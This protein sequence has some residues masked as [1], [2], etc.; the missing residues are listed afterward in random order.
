MNKKY[1]TR[2][3][4]NIVLDT[5]TINR[6]FRIK[7]AGIINGKKVN[8]LVGVSGLLEILGGNVKRM[9][10]FLLRAFNNMADKTVCKIYGVAK[11]TFYAK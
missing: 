3:F 10:D 7:V 9:I 4:G 6:N 5:T 1:M 2:C 8:K 11:V